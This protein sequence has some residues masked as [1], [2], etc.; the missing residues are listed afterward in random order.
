MMKEII[1]GFVVGSS[2]ISCAVT[3]FYMLRAYYKCGSPCN[4][5]PLDKFWVISLLFGVFNSL[6]IWIQL[7]LQN[8]VSPYSVAL[9]VGVIQGLVFSSIGR[10]IYHFPRKLFHIGHEG[11]MHFIAA[12]LY[13]CI[14]VFII[15]PLNMYILQ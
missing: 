13:A 14:Y 5:I 15:Q 1:V 7:N 4:L 10:F 12:V 2:I 8:Q 9:F 3:Y 6:N 11:Y